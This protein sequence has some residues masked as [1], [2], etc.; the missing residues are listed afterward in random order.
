[1]PDFSVSA[2]QMFGKAGCGM[3]MLLLAAREG[4]LGVSM[5][6]RARSVAGAANTTVRMRR[7]AAGWTSAL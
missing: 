3:G 7:N 2:D 5:L 6:V 1:M 4:V